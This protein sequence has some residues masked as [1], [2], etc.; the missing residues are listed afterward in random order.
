M[1]LPGIGRDIKELHRRAAGELRV[2][3]K[4]HTEM[5]SLLNELQQLLVG[6]SIMQVSKLFLACVCAAALLSSLIARHALLSDDGALWLYFCCLCMP[7]G[8]S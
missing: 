4:A 2:D 6:I 3:G 1:F 5:E 8:C 7:W